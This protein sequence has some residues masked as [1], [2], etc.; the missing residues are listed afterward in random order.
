MNRI[1]GILFLCLPATAPNPPRGTPD[2]GPAICGLAYSSLN[3]G[4]IFSS[5]T[6]AQLAKYMQ[7]LTP[8]DAFIAD[9]SGIDSTFNFTLKTD[10]ADAGMGDISLIHAVEKL[11][12]KLEKTKAQAEYLVIDRAEKPRPDVPVSGQAHR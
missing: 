8:I 5:S 4:T 7:G 3:N 2:A 11:G 6:I 1:V 10:R 12:L 9:K